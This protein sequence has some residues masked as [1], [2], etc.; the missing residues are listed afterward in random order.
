MRLR[1][2]LSLLLSLFISCTHKNHIKKDHLIEG[3]CQEK[4]KEAKLGRGQLIW[5][6]VSEGAGTGVSYLITGLAYSTDIAVSFVGGAITGI[7]ICSPYLAVNAI[8]KTSDL[9]SE[10]GRCIANVA[11]DTFEA[12]NPKLGP[13]TYKG[14]KT[15]RCPNLDPIAE[16]LFDV[17]DCYAKQGDKTLSRLQLEKMAD[18]NVFQACLSDASKLKIQ[19]KLNSL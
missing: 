13:K 17:A 12:F 16:G 19:Q 9:D 2:F 15:W 10:A 8:N 7:A 4:F 14:T 3:S 11:G 1:F 5:E 18:S 6:N